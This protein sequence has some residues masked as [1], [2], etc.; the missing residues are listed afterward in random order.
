MKRFCRAAA[1]STMLSLI[2]VSPA[3]AQNAEPPY[4]QRLIQLSEIV[5]SVHYLRKLCLGSE[6]GWRNRMQ[7]LI[8]IEATDPARRARFVAAFNKGYRS[9][10][11]VHRKC[12]SVAIEAEELYRKQGLELASE[13][14]ARYG[15]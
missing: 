10:A 7:A 6:E 13:I 2:A 15:N 5:G 3:A 12:N 9:F 14:I 4:E 1:L 8:D 11:S